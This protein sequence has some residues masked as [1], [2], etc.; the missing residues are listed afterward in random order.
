MAAKARTK[1]EIPKYSE[2]PRDVWVIAAI[3]VLGTFMSQLDTSV[4]NVGL[5]SVSNSLDS[6]LATTQWI[7]SGYLLALGASIPVCGWMVRR[8]GGRRVWLG[9]IVAFT[10]AS[11]LCALAQTVEQLIALRALQGIGGGM[12][13]PAGQILVARAAGPRR[14]GRVMSTTGVAVLLAPVLGPV[15]GGLLIEASWRWLFL[16]NVPVGVI[17]LCLGMKFLDHDHGE[18]APRLD[19]PGLLLVSLGL[20]S[21]IYAI[22]EAG[23]SESVTKV[24]VVTA[25][26]TGVMAL[27]A[28][29]WRE[30]RVDAPLLNI[31]VLNNRV[32]ANALVSSTFSAAA[33]YGMLIL[34]PLYLEVQRGYTPLQTGLLMFATGIGA[35]LFFPVSGRLTDR[36]GGG[37]V[38]VCG[39]IGCLV[40]TAPMVFLPA[41]AS[42]VVVEF[43]LA[44]SGV[45]FTVSL[46]PAMTAA[47][48][49]VTRE[50]LPDA[51]PMIM[52]G[53]RVG[54]SLGTAIL[55]VVV[56]RRLHDGVAPVD[57]F[58]AAFVGAMIAIA[59]AI[60]PAVALARAH[61]AATRADTGSA[62]AEK[63]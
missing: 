47:Y 7:A 36:Y 35:A 20:P 3:L 40:S 44:L 43:V 48:A 34:T 18:P 31:R 38:S 14:M 30:L 23:R 51:A 11:L 57:A 5:D 22:T 45:A 58:H 60:V 53:T 21:I 26:V 46:M 41:D 17:A 2:I 24:A 25:G 19:V 28:F 33:L 49:A 39:L 62:I 27:G 1:A 54:G 37:P 59:V 12:L 42:I 6:S 29:V 63:Y 56:E 55:V 4:V 9:A 61:I 16:M 13:L 50:Q 52:I 15:I 10:V 32:F 8:Y